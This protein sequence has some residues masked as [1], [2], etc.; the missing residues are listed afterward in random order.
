M[1]GL[2]DARVEQHDGLVSLCGTAREAPA[3]SLTADVTV[4]DVTDETTGVGLSRKL[5][6]RC[7]ARGRK[8]AS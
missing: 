6:A 8:R 4:P 5:C 2:A 1:E 7:A 3:A